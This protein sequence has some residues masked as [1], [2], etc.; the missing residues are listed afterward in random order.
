MLHVFF[1]QKQM[2]DT[3]YRGSVKTKFKKKLKNV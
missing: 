2:E 3:V 1:N